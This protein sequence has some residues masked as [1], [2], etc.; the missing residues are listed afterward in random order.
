[1]PVF[2]LFNFVML[3]FSGSVVT[4]SGR[5]Y[6]LKMDTVSDALYS[7]FAPQSVQNFPPIF[8]PE[9]YAQVHASS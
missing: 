9:Q 8:F 1:M 7:L 5:N 6:H 4:A 3:L 2:G